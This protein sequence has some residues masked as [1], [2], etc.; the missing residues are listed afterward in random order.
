MVVAHIMMQLC[1]RV[2]NLSLK[3]M[4]DAVVL[5]GMPIIG[6]IH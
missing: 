6:I 3:R 4:T 1:K 5:I 2:K